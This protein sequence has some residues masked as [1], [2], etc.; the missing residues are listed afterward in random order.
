MSGERRGPLDTPVDDD[1]LRKAARGEGPDDSPGS[2]AGAENHGGRGSVGPAGGLL[3]EIGEE[4]VGVGVAAHQTAAFEPE[5]VDCA[6]GGGD[7]VG[8]GNEP[9]RRLLMGDRDVPA[10]I[11]IAI[12]AREKR[13]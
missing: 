9:E 8:S 7:V 13:A 10:D 4:A 1:D 12:E 3:V 11:G 6:E 2:T 5:R